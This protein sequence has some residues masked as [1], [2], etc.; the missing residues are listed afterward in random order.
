MVSLES[1]IFNIDLNDLLFLLSWFLTRKWLRGYHPFLDQ[2]ALWKFV[3]Q[4]EV[5]KVESE[6][7]FEFIFE[8]VIPVLKNTRFMWLVGKVAR[9]PNTFTISPLMFCYKS[10]TEWMQ[11]RDENT[12][13]I[14]FKGHSSVPQVNWLDW[15]SNIVAWK[16]V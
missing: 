16:N 1:Q 4:E 7:F 13:K 15:N 6:I 12:A 9:P 5:R 11:M 2:S 8:E 14:C 3:V 10:Y